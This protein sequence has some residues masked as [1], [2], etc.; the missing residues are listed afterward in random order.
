MDVADLLDA[1]RTDLAVNFKCAVSSS[2]RCLCDRDPRIIMAEDSCIF[3]VSRRVRCDLTKFQMISGV[4]RLQK[5]DTIFRL[6][7]FLY[8][9]ES[10]FCQTVFFADLCHHTESLRLNKNPAL[11]AFRG[12]DFASLCI[13]STE[14][15]LA[16]PAGIQNCLMHF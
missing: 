13:I 15:P 2:D 9:I 16:V 4:R 1:G 3:L 8:R 10:F 7:M 5:H 6:E 11:F 12:T 14:E